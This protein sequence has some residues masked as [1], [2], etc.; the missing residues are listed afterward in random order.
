MYVSSFKIITCYLCYLIVKFIEKLKPKVA[1]EITQKQHEGIK[2][3]LSKGI[4]GDTTDEI[5]SQ[6]N[7]FIRKKATPRFTK[8][9]KLFDSAKAGIVKNILSGTQGKQTDRP[10]D[11]PTDRRT[12]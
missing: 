5:D 1:Q 2:A 10:T 4:L 12:D 3:I 8:A 9:R 11:R 7:S 6:L